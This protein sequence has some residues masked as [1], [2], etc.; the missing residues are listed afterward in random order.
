MIKKIVTYKV[1]I[2]DYLRCVQFAHDSILTNLNTY[3]K[4][5]QTN[6]H[7]I[8]ND[9]IVGKVG[10]FAV[11]QHLSTTGV[12][13]EPDLT[14][15]SENKKTF[16]ADLT[17]SGFNIHVKSQSRIQSEA[18]GTSWSFHPTD[19][20]I[21]NPKPNDVI[22]LCLVDDLTVEILHYDKASYYLDLYSDPLIKALKN[23]KKV[24]YFT[25]ILKKNK[26]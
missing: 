22:F 4:R 14:V 21:K 23:H 13:N 7:K 8:V 17:T 6:I 26:K 12:V 2:K 15:Y 24:I 19:N 18:Y 9:I 20:L 25:D 10:E 16:D 5:N 3:A 11:Y 1:D